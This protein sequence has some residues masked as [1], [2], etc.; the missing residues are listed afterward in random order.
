MPQWVLVCPKCKQKFVHSQV[1][2]TAIKEAFFSSY[3]LV[4]RPKLAVEVLTCPNC[5][6][7]SFYKQ[8]DLIYSEDDADETAKGRGA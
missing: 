7:K 8:F 6:V 3:G 1:D 5:K 2:E 4:A